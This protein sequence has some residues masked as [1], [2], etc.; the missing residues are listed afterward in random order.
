MGEKAEYKVIITYMDGNSEIWENVKSITEDEGMVCIL[1]N[2]LELSDNR[3]LHQQDSI[4]IHR[5]RKMTR[6][7]V[8]SVADHKANQ[9]AFA[10]YRSRLADGLRFVTGVASLDEMGDGGDD[11]S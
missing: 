8:C 9:A 3:I 6:T 4:P 1:Y 2:D 10:D 7:Y 5:I 11:A